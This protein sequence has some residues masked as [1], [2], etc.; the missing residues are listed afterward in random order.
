VVSNVASGAINT[1][2][3]SGSN[4][5][6]LT[7]FKILCISCHRFSLFSSLP[8]VLRQ[9]FSLPLPLFQA[10]FR[11]SQSRYLSLRCARPQCSLS[12]RPLRRPSQTSF[13]GSRYLARF[14]CV[15]CVREWERQA[16]RRQT[17][18][19]EAWKYIT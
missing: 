8:F 2:L 4:L 17:R 16:E 13:F 10:S 14:S 19:R 12:G 11:L 5:Y 3:E 7:Q 6:L 1:T 18:F 9:D 15:A